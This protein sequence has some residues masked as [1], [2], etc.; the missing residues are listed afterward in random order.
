MIS[1]YS[2]IAA[3]LLVEIYYLD[4]S[5]AAPKC[6]G[7][8]WTINPDW[9]AY[10]VMVILF[11]VFRN[12]VSRKNILYGL[13]VVSCVVSVYYAYAFNIEWPVM[14]IGME[15]TDPEQSKE[16]KK[17]MLESNPDMDINSIPD[18]LPYYSDYDPYSDDAVRWRKIGQ[19]YGGKLY[20][21]GIERHGAAMF[22]GGILAID[23]IDYL[24]TPRNAF[25]ITNI[26]KLVSCVILFYII[27]DL[28]SDLEHRSPIWTVLYTKLFDILA[29]LVIQLCLYIANSPTNIG[30]I[31][32]ILLGNRIF[33]FL[34]KFTYAFY[35][36]HLTVLIIMVFTDYPIKKDTNG[37]WIN[38]LNT[39]YVWNMCIKC[40]GITLVLSMITYYMIEY[41]MQK[42]RKKYIQ[43]K[44]KTKQKQL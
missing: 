30:K 6:S 24:K 28:R 33:K 27:D 11:V 15:T 31:I 35:L 4:P 2:Q 3:F 43:N 5:F 42:C 41:P 38:K 25:T 10:V 32:G 39:N 1:K 23:F 21:T 13:F 17:S 37:E 29:Y 36:I 19:L 34:G 40:F 22:L 18:A 12:N 44:Y 9:H 8:G 20:F 16:F 14:G 26:I 7:V